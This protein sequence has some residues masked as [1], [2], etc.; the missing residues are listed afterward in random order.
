MDGVAAMVQLLREQTKLRD[1]RMRSR[2][3]KVSVAER[4][5]RQSI[6]RDCLISLTDSQRKAGIRR[7]A[8]LSVVRMV[9]T[10]YPAGCA[11][12]N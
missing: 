6:E 12:V 2:S 1:Q 3:C 4:S 9:M 10:W 7:R 8:Q 5:R 11:L